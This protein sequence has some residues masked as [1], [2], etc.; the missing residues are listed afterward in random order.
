MSLV[1]TAIF[2]LYLLSLMYL[3]LLCCTT[4]TIEA[5][6]LDVVELL[7]ESL[8]DAFTSTT[9]ELEFKDKRGGM[10]TS[11]MVRTLLLTCDACGWSCATLHT[12]VCC[13][14]YVI[15]SISLRVVYCYMW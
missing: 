5:D 9:G 1:S 7:Q 12:R 15:P 10:S 8:L 6:A 14:I 4:I 13:C 3:T 11:K 2:A